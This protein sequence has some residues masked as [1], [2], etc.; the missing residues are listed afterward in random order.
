[1]RGD[2]LVGF[3][4]VFLCQEWMDL[5][6]VEDD[7]IIVIQEWNRNKLLFENYEI[8]VWNMELQVFFMVFVEWKVN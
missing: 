6:R 8:Y 1:M 3:L 7:F 2:G 5:F 4:I